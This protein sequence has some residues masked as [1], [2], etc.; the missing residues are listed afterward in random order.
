MPS[1]GGVN[2]FGYAVR[3]ITAD[4]PRQAQENKFFGLS[5]IER[6]DGGLAGRF[7]SAEGLHYGIDATALATVQETF[8]SYNDGIARALVDNRGVTWLNV[9][10]EGFQPQG[11]VLQDSRGYY[12]A[13]QARFKHL[14]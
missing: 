11:R 12:Q 4:N 8:R 1:Y 7:T 13:Y 6:L 9:V 10:L 2:I 14:T 5:G 3:I